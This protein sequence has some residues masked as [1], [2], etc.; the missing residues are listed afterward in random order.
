LRLHTCPALRCLQL[1]AGCVTLTALSRVRAGFARAFQTML[2]F[3]WA[4]LAFLSA[5]LSASA[6]AAVSTPKSTPRFRRVDSGSSS[7]TTPCT[8]AV[9]AALIA[10]YHATNGP[11]WSHNDGWLSGLN[12]C[13]GKSKTLHLHVL[14]VRP[15]SHAFL[16][17]RAPNN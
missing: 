12:P 3:R 7:E 13:S 16:L 6:R 11:S 4:A 2:L 15:V 1:P 9:Y 8:D 10:F 17:C 5:F 14:F